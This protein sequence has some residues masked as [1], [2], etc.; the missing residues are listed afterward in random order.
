MSYM[1][2]FMSF[3]MIQVIDSIESST[4]ILKKNVLANKDK[5]LFCASSITSHT[6][7]YFVALPKSVNTEKCLWLSNQSCVYQSRRYD[8]IIGVTSLQEIFHRFG[9]IYCFL[10][11]PIVGK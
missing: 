5:L 9:A 10:L 3:L 7:R 2:R 11:V 1:Q 4:Q 6:I 8:V